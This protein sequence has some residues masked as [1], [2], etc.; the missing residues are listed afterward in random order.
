MAATNDSRLD[1]LKEVEL[2][3]KRIDVLNERMAISKEKQAAKLRAQIE[4]ELKILKLKQQQLAED[5]KRISRN[6]K[7]RQRAKERKELEEEVKD[8]IED[9][10][11]SFSKLDKVVQKQITN[12]TKGNI[13]VAAMLERIKELETNRL[14]LK[15]DELAQNNK[16]LEF[17]KESKNSMF[18]SATEMAN[19]TSKI[20][21]NEKERLDL[22]KQIAG[23][24]ELDANMA[25]INLHYQQQW[26][27]KQERINELSEHFNELYSE[28]PS[29]IQ[30]MADSMKG[31][32][33][34]IKQASLMAAGFAIFALVVEHFVELDKAAEEYRKTTGLT[35]DMTKELD[36][37]AHEIE[38]NYRKIGVTA[39]EVYDVSNDLG[40]VFSDI[41][42][43]S[44]ETL[45]SL[46]AIQSR[47]G[48]TSDTAAK[49]QGVFEQ[50]S[51][52]SSETAAS[53]QMQVASLAQQAKVSPKEVLDDIAESAETT[54][55]FFKG[56]VN[57]LKSQVIQAHQ[58]G[59]N[60][61][62]VA[63]VAEKLLDFEGGIDDELTAA[64]FVGG[65]FNLSRARALA[66]EGK[67]VEAQ[68]ATLDAIQESGDFRQKDYFTQQQLAKAA[69]M[70]TEEI[71][72]QLGN[73]EKLSH[74][75]GEDLKNAQAAVASGLDTT[76]LNDEQLKQKIEEFAL[77]N[78][79]SGSVTDLQNTF[80]SI[81][82]NLGGVFLPVLNG[83]A[84]VFKF[85][86]DHGALLG[87]LL[88][89]AV[90][91][92]VVM[93]INNQKAAAAKAAEAALQLEV[94]TLQRA[95]LMQS[96][97]QQV[98]DT[99]SLAT[100][101]STAVAKT[102]GGFAMGGPLSIIAGLAMV[103]TIIGAIASAGKQAKSIGDGMFPSAGG[104]TISTKEGGLFQGTKND[105]VLVGP[106]LASEKRLNGALSAGSSIVGAGIGVAL[107]VQEIKQMRK[108]M[109]SKSTDVYMDGSKVTAN[110]SSNVNKSTRNNFALA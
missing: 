50:V 26:E 42:H 27:H 96:A 32:V 80:A 105:D 106:N 89:T 6:E 15:G 91:Y 38:V 58:L 65:K 98:K 99:A 68:N 41:A 49:V 86:T 104:P 103:G 44:G 28:L 85:I 36:H 34:L 11:D 3:N 61:N 30:G 95:Q 29:E 62:K 8:N 35:V 43:F 78:K 12:Q 57:L 109:A 73:R 70:S 107:L 100:N 20:S 84:N 55:K 1:S 14:T 92:S 2:I 13:V 75:S 25:R 66:M 101:S 19:A 53:L 48:A 110:I 17:L 79:I 81:G 7:A 52:V 60:L 72:K 82:A 77:Q 9:E 88:A 40:N 71:V 37:N 74:L 39:K 31:F 108:E 23:F 69:N 18:E 22:E 76:D 47:T 5:D 64:T 97:A 59:T 51:G 10:I 45:A 46:A 90:G 16:V 93:Y 102:L 87:G 67:I 4:D 56:D 21:K 63:D 33:H 94:L 83:I 54:S 24:S